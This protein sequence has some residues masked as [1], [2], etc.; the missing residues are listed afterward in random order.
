MSLTSA[1]LTTLNTAATLGITNN[2]A[3]LP[4]SMALK[5]GTTFV[6]PEQYVGTAVKNLPK[7]GDA[8]P[9]VASW[10]NQFA[11]ANF[12]GY[13]RSVPIA[14]IKGAL[15]WKKLTLAQTMPVDTTLNV[16]IWD[17]KR[18]TCA[19][20]RAQVMALMSMGNSG[21]IDATPNKIVQGFSDALTAVP[22][23]N[24]GTTQDAGWTGGGGVRAVLNR[25]GSYAEKMFADTTNGAGDTAAT[26]ASFGPFEGMISAGDIASLFGG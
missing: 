17:A 5:D 14:S 1:Q 13:Y 9:T 12:F 25:L 3:T 11:V 8:A 19:D 7:T 10:Y 23:K 6:V 4:A 26:A 21:T 15:D 2:N 20:Y 22:S 18:A 16:A 24:D